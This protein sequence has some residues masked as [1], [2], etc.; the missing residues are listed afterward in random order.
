MKSE[1]VRTTPASAVRTFGY[2]AWKEFQSTVGA[3]DREIL[4]KS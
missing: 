2:S 1:A 4:K 3:R